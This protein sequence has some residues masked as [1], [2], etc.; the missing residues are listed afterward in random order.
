VV[1][2]LDASC[3]VGRR[4]ALDDE[5]AQQPDEVVGLLA[6]YGIAGALCTHS[7]AEEHDPL[8]G[9]QEMRAVAARHPVFSTCAVILPPGT[10]EMPFTGDPAGLVDYLGSIGARA[11]RLAPSKHGYSL[12]P[13]VCDDLLAALAETAFPVC[14]GLGEIGWERLDEVLTRHPAL[15][16]ILE[17]IGYR[18]GRT[19][20]P[21]LARHRGLHIE[22]S[23]YVGHRAIEELVDRY[24]PWRP[25]FGTDQPFLDPGA[26]L[27]RIL[28]ADLTDEAREAVAGGNLAR[29]LARGELA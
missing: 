23:T 28:Y 14:V 21:M 5:F 13:T 15:R 10:G 1:T 26:A 24:G 25:V 7:W 3:R 18:H 29:L 12:T 8:A 22:T 19:V 11:V 27:A 20:L 9:N 17:R 2:F 6:S 16:V 4:A